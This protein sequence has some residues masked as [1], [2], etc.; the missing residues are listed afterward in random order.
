[1]V[2]ESPEGILID[3]WV[4]ASQLFSPCYIG[5]WSACQHWDFTEQIFDK[6]WVLTS[7]RING[8]VQKAGNFHFLVKKTDPVKFFGLKSVWK[9]TVKVQVSDPHKTI[10]DVLDDPALAG[11][12]RFSLD[13]LQKYLRSK[14]SNTSLLLEYAHKMNNRTI[15]KRL[16]FLLSYLKFEDTAVIE[17]CRNNIS[18]GNSQIDPSIKG[19]RLIKKWGLW[20]SCEFENPLPES[21]P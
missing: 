9:E 17:E 11:G 13:M 21:E 19:H 7:R 6:I 5:G 18:Q 3:P 8:K 12:I 4:L 2:S 15:F 1:M 14:H 20:L 16:G 10:I